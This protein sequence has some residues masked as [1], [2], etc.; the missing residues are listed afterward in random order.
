MENK[1]CLSPWKREQ[2]VKPEFEN[3]ARSPPGALLEK[4]DAHPVQPSILILFHN[5]KTQVT[6]TKRLT[7]YG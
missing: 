4:E 7:F 6:Y 5:T 2:E 1:K 3:P